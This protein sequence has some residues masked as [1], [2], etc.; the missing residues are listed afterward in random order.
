MFNGFYSDT[1]EQAQKGIYVG[2][3]RIFIGDETLDVSPKPV[4]IDTST[5]Y[6]LRPIDP[7]DK[8]KDIWTL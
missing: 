8:P 6:A 1:L 7:N 4:K 5:D 3:D 2:W